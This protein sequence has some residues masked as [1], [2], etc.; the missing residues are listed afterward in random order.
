[1]NVIGRLYRSLRSNGVVTTGHKVGRLFRA[2]KNRALDRLSLALEQ[3]RVRNGFIIRK[4][5]G[6]LMLLDIGDVGI[7]RE[8]ALKGVHELVSTRQIQTELRP[9]MRVVEVGANIGYYALIAASIVG[10][11]G[12]IYAFEPSP[13]NLRQLRANIALNDL[14]EK[15][16]VIPMGVGSCNSTQAFHIMSKGN[17]SSFLLRHED[18]IIKRIESIDVEVTSLDSYFEGA[19]DGRIDFVRMDVEGYEEEVIVGMRGILTSDHPPGGMFI[20]V[21]SSLLQDKGSS[22]AAFF[23]QLKELG[24]EATRAFFRGRT[25]IMARSTDEVL[26]HDLLEQGYWETFFTHKDRT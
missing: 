10:D 8:L 6:S 21:H 4:V 9:G 20:E 13:H 16:D 7:S 5:Q 1:M 19:A 11:T 22:A 3:R 26:S 2:S 14:C 15:I 17:M 24:Y 12:H 25:D 18:Q 23:R